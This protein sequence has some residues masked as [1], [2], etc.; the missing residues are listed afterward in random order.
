MQSGLFCLNSLD[1]VISNRKGVWLVLLLKCFIEKSIF[2]ATSVDPDQTPRSSA[3]DL[4]L[5]CLPMS[6]LW[7]AR[8]KWV[9]RYSIF[10]VSRMGSVNDE[11]VKRGQL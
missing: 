7:D 2:N 8:H 4:V 1:R 9:K 5:H 3:S 10:R 11:L 6:L